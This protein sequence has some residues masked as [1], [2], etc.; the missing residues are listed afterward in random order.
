M[1]E[2]GLHGVVAWGDWTGRILK[3]GGSVVLIRVILWDGE[4]IM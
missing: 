1:G 4:K 3:R 2:G